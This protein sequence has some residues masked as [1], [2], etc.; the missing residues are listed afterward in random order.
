MQVNL[1]ITKP[2]FVDGNTH[3]EV[4]VAPSQ[5]RK[6]TMPPQT[7]KKKIVHLPQIAPGNNDDISEGGGGGGGGGDVPAPQERDVSTPFPDQANSRKR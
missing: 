1:S 2:S 6:L 7:P 4:V 5:K 3:D